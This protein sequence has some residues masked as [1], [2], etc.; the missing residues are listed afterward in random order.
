M[1][2]GDWNQ[3]KNKVGGSRDSGSSNM[4]GDDDKANLQFVE[5]EAMCLL[6]M[7][8]DAAELQKIFGIL[9]VDCPETLHG[10]SALLLKY[11]LR[12]LNSEDLEKSDDGGLST[13]LKLYECLSQETK[14]Q[15]NLKKKEELEV[16]KKKENINLREKIK[17]KPLFDV[18]KL[19]DFKISGTVGAPAR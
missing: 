6:T 16:D 1:E 18:Q 14:D 10:K 2:S 13:F 19:K 5:R 15:S 12:H 9:T 3:L 7:V 8:E 17:I 11:L 4:S